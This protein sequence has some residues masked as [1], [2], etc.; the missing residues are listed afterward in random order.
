M[1]I[2]K[3]GGNTWDEGQLKPVAKIT[4]DLPAVTHY[5]T[6]FDIIEEAWSE[7]NW[8]GLG[9]IQ[10]NSLFDTDNPLT[11]G[12]DETADNMTGFNLF[13][14]DGWS[15]SQDSGKSY[16]LEGDEPFADFYFPDKF[17]KGQGISNCIKY[18]NTSVVPPTP[19]WVPIFVDPVGVTV[20]FTGYELTSDDIFTLTY[21]TKG[22]SDN[23]S[24]NVAGITLTGAD[25][26]DDTNTLGVDESLTHL[27]AVNGVYKFIWKL[28]FFTSGSPLTLL[29]GVIDIP[30][31]RG[32]TFSINTTGGGQYSFWNQYRYT[33]TPTGRFMEDFE[34]VVDW[35][36]YNSSSNGTYYDY[37]T[38][39]Y[40]NYDRPTNNWVVGTPESYERSS[41]VTAQ[42]TGQALMVRGAGAGAWG[43]YDSNRYDYLDLPVNVP[44]TAGTGG[45]D[46]KLSYGLRS[47]LSDG[48]SV[49]V[50]VVLSSG[51]VY[52]LGYF[53]R[54]SNNT[55]T[56]YWDQN[57]VEGWMT[58]TASSSTIYNFSGTIDTIRFRFISDNW[59]Q[60]RGIII[61]N[62][63]LSTVE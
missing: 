45:F 29:T 47:D 28:R 56:N 30:V 14:S 58:Y 42:S 31:T 21:S 15:G 4:L 3:G 10:A 25:I 19:D 46:L 39:S 24:F 17:P 54:W 48:D 35:T 52:G 13:A 11:I 5:V 57:I 49:E 41:N 62:V 37:N 59:Y 61:D 40:Q 2:Q 22:S 55:V 32:S 60:S 27:T 34:S 26:P 38:W 18:P 44:I 8:S 12:W 20:D 50:Q 16:R 23:P 6:T 9:W 43:S 1:A 36:I 33:G 63:H 7:D 53:D 51:D